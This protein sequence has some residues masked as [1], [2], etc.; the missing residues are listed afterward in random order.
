[1]LWEELKKNNI[2]AKLNLWLDE[3][4]EAHVFLTANGKVLDITATQYSRF[5]EKPVVFISRRKAKKHF[6]YQTTKTFKNAKSLKMYQIKVGWPK[7][8]V[9]GNY[10]H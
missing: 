1:M 7:E 5:A 10:G 4:G 6:F 2:K 9:V 8:Q 3:S